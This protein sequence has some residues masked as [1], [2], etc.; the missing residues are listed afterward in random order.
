MHYPDRLHSHVVN[1]L[2]KNYQSYYDKSHGC[3]S[4]ANSTTILS[5]HT[6]Q[7]LLSLR[8]HQAQASRQP[9]KGRDALLDGRARNTATISFFEQE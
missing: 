1:V 3:F 4:A 5:T 8:Q 7:N 6:V 9:Q 2:S